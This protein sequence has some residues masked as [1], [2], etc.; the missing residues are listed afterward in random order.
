L[1]GIEGTGEDLLDDRADSL[2]LGEI[3]VYEVST[4]PV[5]ELRAST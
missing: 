3:L 4:L 1:E 2:Y 5:L